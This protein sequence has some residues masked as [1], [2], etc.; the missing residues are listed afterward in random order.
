[1]TTQ[2][3]RVLS[4]R[5]ATQAEAFAAKGAAAGLPATLMELRRIGAEEFA[6]SGFPTTKNED[7][8]YTSVAPIA[9]AQYTAAVESQPSQT[10]V[11]APDLRGF[12]PEGVEWPVIVFINGRFA[13]EYT[14]LSLL[15]EGIRVLT[16]SEAAEKEPELLKRYLSKAAP[17]TRDGFTALNAAYAGV[18]TLIH[19]AREMASDR[20]VHL[21][22]VMDRSGADT[23]AHFRHVMVAERNCTATVVESFVTLDEVSYFTNSVTE[24]YLEAGANLTVVCVQRESEKAHHVRT[25]EGHQDRDSHF[26]SFVFQTGGALSRS[27]VH[28]K[29]DGEGCGTTLNGLSMLNGTQHGDHQTRV[30]H[31]APNCFS[32]EVYKML[33]DGKSHGVFNGKVYVHPEAQ[34]TDG[35]QTNQTILLSDEAQIDTKP[36]LEIFADDVKCTHGATVGQ[37]D[38]LSLFY[39]KSRGIGSQ[40]ALQLLT[41]AFAADVLETIENEPI[42]LALEEMTLARFTDG[43][44][45]HG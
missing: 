11:T 3:L 31:I 4:P 24:V 33:L 22:H 8:H 32:R 43:I 30:E 38:A 29:L 14:D 44:S 18:G 9:E 15:P 25:V 34:Q 27:N 13:P 35:K 45:V 40:I 42:K 23:M 5:F 37:L 16:L 21:L 1:M 39:L 26:Q 36:Q 17:A 7:W 28:T 19:V 6:V 10:S 20:P 12:T 41:Y 2:A